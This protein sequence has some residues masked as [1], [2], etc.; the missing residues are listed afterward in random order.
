MAT[1]ISTPALST[2]DSASTLSMHVPPPASPALGHTRPKL[3]STR[4]AFE[5]QVTPKKRARKG[6]S[7]VE[8]GAV[9]SE[10]DA[11]PRKRARKSIISA[12]LKRNTSRDQVTPKD[13]S[14]IATEMDRERARVS[15]NT[16]ANPSES[17]SSNPKRPP[18][19]GARGKDT[20]LR[21][22][23]RGE[24]SRERKFLVSKTVLSQVSTYFASLFSPSSTTFY[25][26]RE[27]GRLEFSLPAYSMEAVMIILNRLHGGVMTDDALKPDTLVQV[28]I[29]ANKYKCI[30]IMHAQIYDWFK[31]LKLPDKIQDLACLT[32]AAVLSRDPSLLKAMNARA[33]CCLTPL[34]W[35]EYRALCEKTG[36]RWE[37]TMLLGLHIS[38]KSLC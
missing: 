20:F 6:S 23:L 33:A 12:E 26:I 24:P 34:Q 32:I 5:N 29:H 19:T 13:K 31:R 21:V 35:R 9:A 1:D 28:M 3:S 18:M 11:T 37:G 7:P 17:D 36:Y 15:N 22:Y 8:P 38:K 4:S 2:D 16:L 10:D 30:E 27:D 25:H 14:S